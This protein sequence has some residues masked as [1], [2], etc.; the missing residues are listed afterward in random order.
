MCFKRALKVSVFVAIGLSS[1]LSFAQSSS[2]SAGSGGVQGNG[3]PLANGTTN[4]KST[5]GMF[6]SATSGGST[7]SD[8]NNQF[9]MR[10]DGTGRSFDSSN[11]GVEGAAGAASSSSTGSSTGFSSG[12][13]NGS[14]NWLNTASASGADGNTDAGSGTFDPWVLTYGDLHTNGNETVSVYYQGVIRK[15]ETILSP[16]NGFIPSMTMSASVFANGTSIDIL[17]LGA[18]LENNTLAF[19]YSL[20]GLTNPNVSVYLLDQA[21]YDSTDSITTKLAGFSPATANQ[22]QG[23]WSSSWSSGANA[24]SYVLSQDIYFGFKVDRLF[25]PGSTDPNQ[26]AVE[27]HY[28]SAAKTRSP[29]PEPASMIALSAGLLGFVRRRKPA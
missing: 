6:S 3:D 27:M 2:V 29:V 22:I 24:P 12:T 4:G 15:N 19:S 10:A 26:S 20:D 11:S 13:S 7:N 25:L 14:A 1:V 8:S 16:G 28:N 18:K 21:A 5:I 23:L 9:K 17:S